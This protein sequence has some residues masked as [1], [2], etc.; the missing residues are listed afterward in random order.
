MEKLERELIE[1]RLKYTEDDKSVKLLEK[2]RSMFVKLLKE[3]AL[4]YLKAQR[5]N[6]ESMMESAIRP[7]GVVL[8]YK[9]LMR[10]AARDENTL[11]QLENQL[12]ALLLEDARIEE[13]WELITN[14]TL[15]QYPVAPRKLR[16]SLIG[17]ILGVIFGFIF[18][19]FKERKSGYIFEESYLENL[20]KTKILKDIKINQ[21]EIEKQDAVIFFKELMTLET[22]KNI[23][24]LVANNVDNNLLI[25]F[26]NIIPKGQ[27]KFSLCNDL[28]NLDVNQKTLLLINMDSL[29]RSEI[30]NIRN[31]VSILNINLLGIVLISD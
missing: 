14:P 24:I 18:S 3:R 31:R 12:R 29:K 16:I 10:E 27:Y 13:P 1:L 23:G 6:V 17:M 30:I 9:G 21:L 7:K 19:I 4:G 28:I 25:K 22:D 8:K 2:K 20:F 11:I 5:I 15:S 26:K